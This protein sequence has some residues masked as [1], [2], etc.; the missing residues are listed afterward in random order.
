MVGPT[1]S[2]A[3][4]AWPNSAQGGAHGLRRAR[5]TCPPRL[6]HGLR[7]HCR[8]SYSHVS[9]GDAQS[10]MG[11]LAAQASFRHPRG[12]PRRALARFR[13]LLGPAYTYIPC[14]IHAHRAANSR[15]IRNHGR[16]C[17]STCLSK[18]LFFCI[19]ISAAKRRSRHR[20][21]SIYEGF[22]GGGRSPAIQIVGGRAYS[23]RLSP[24]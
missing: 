19:Y 4:A 1:G 24:K 15:N 21:R 7:A 9:Q 10:P 18:K 11:P 8:R 16:V 5:L 12:P 6:T 13:G 3:Q 20:V 2:A 22:G 17:L 23:P 14:D